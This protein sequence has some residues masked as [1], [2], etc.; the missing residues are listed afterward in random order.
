MDQVAPLASFTVPWGGQQIELREMGFDA[1][2]SRLLRVH[3]REGRRFTV[4]DIDA[5][6][7]RNWGAAMRD[8]AARELAREQPAAGRGGEGA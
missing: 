6:T 8:W 2:G 7:A 1:G 5:H 4:F 3:I